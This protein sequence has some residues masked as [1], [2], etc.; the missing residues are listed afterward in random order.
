[1]TSAHPWSGQVWFGEDWACFEGLCGDARAHHH[2]AAQVVVGLSGSVTVEGPCGAVVGEAVLIAPRALHAIVPSDR[3]VRVVYL[4]SF[5]GLAHSW[6]IPTRPAAP[7]AL[8]ARWADRLRGPDP[9][10]S[11]AAASAA[12][13]PRRLDPRLAAALQDLRGL[14]EVD[15]DLG[16][17]ARRVGLSPARLRALTRAELGAPLAHWRAWL[18]LERAIGALR[19]GDSL[20]AAAVQAGF[21]DQAH[22]SRTMRRF[23]GITPQTASRVVARPPRPAT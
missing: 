18:R 10:R 3:I 6:G 16:D 1:M 5:G 23:F 14:T 21:S 11:L 17:V 7:Y 8:P 15:S 4:Q 22:L 2:L 19:R 12:C 9:G 20:A 13:E